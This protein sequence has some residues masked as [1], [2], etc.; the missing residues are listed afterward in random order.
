MVVSVL[1]VRAPAMCLRILSVHAEISVTPQ[2][3]RFVKSGSE[4]ELGGGSEPLFLFEKKL[5]F[6]FNLIIW[7]DELIFARFTEFLLNRSGSRDLGDVAGDVKLEQI[8]EKA[9]SL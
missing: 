3:A 9:L 1:V 2:A 8:S 7:N 5:G 6:F 4:K